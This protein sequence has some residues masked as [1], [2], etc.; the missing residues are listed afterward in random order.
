[1]NIAIICSDNNHPIFP[2]LQEWIRNLPSEHNAD[3]YQNSSDLKGGDLLFLIS[4]SQIIGD[5]EKSLFKSCIVLHASDLP[6]GRGWSPHI[7]EVLGGAE[8]LTI[9]AVEA[10]EPVDSGD[11]WSKLKINIPRNL[12][13][14]EVNQLIFNAELKLMTYIV[15]NYHQIIP[16]P[17]SLDGGGTYYRKRTQEDSEIDP[18]DTIENQFDLLRICDPNRFPAFV[19]VRG[20][21]YKILIKDYES[22]DK[23]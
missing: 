5:K 3:L 6:K 23:N 9:S 19:K 20:R 22:K 8:E 13:W 18:R 16:T 4:C 2:M 17:Q 10:A 12:I 21:K 7:W 11:V 1:M 15:E 14:N